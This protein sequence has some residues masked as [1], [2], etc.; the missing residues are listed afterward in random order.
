MVIK[1]QNERAPMIIKRVEITPP[2][3]RKKP[4]LAPTAL[5]TTVL[6][7]QRCGTV[8]HTL[9]PSTQKQTRTVLE[10]LCQ[11]SRQSKALTVLISSLILGTLAYRSKEH[12]QAPCADQHRK[13]LVICQSCQEKQRSNHSHHSKAKK[14]Y[15]FTKILLSSTF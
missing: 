11:V 9:L 1:E 13:N 14:R 2:S 10:E 15:S 4:K 8:K 12:N 3:S 6:E 5:P 7:S